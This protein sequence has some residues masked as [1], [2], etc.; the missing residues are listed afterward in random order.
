MV[1]DVSFKSKLLKSVTVILESTS[2]WLLR[3]SVL[4]EF[5]GD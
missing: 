3:V 4:M 2:K 1:Q 5:F